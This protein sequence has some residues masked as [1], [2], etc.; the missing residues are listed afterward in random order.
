MIIKTEC[1]RGSV[2]ATRA[3]ANLALFE[4]IDGF[5]NS[6]RI[7]KRLGHLSPIELRGEALRRPG[8]GRTNE[9][10]TPSTRSEQ[11]ISTSHT[12]GEPDGDT[13]A[14]TSQRGRWHRPRP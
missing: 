9:P 4:Y 1:I 12:P 6:R 2:L 11:L 5:Y 8:N 7:Q 14:A 3:E 13:A 10:E